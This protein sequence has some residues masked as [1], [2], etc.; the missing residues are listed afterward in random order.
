MNIAHV[1]AHQ[2]DEM[3][4]LGTLIKYRE[5]GGHNL[6]F[7]CVTNGDKGMSWDPSVSLSEAAAIREREMQ[8]VAEQF[9]A[10]YICLGEPDEFLY[11]TKEAR[12]KLIDALRVCRADLIFTHWTRDYNLDHTTTSQLVFQASML[13]VI[14]TIQTEHE[15]LRETPRICYCDV[16]EG[17]GFPGTHFVELSEET[18][19]EKLRILRLHK[20]QMEVSGKMGPDYADR[21]RDRNIALGLRARVKYAEV[22]TPCLAD[23]RIPL[24]NMLP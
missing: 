3:F 21:I 19:R 9:D 18:F 7:I 5:Q 2:D 13:S 10:Q 16:G 15:P 22:F 20:S 17:Y 12:L 14:A 1:G 23:R 6:S 24:A 8:M 4:A 11:D